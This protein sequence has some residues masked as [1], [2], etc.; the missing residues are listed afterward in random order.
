MLRVAHIRLWDYSKAWG[1]LHGLICPKF[2]L[3]WALIAASYYFLVHP[4]ILNALH[5]FAQNLAFSF[6]IGLFFG[7]FLIDVAHSLQLTAKLQK[8]AEENDVIVRYENLKL[9]MRKVREE[10]KQKY[11]F[12]SPFRSDRPLSE[13]LKEM[14]ESLE[15]RRR[16]RT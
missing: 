2:S 12:F 8:F 16:P 11:H 1:N 5:W 6:V 7:V 13:H 15:Q 10:T 4:Q 3:I 14:R 9:Q